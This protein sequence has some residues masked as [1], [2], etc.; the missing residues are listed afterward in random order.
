MRNAPP[1]Y[2]PTSGRP[3]SQLAPDHSLGKARA[4]HG[5]I[6]VAGVTSAFCPPTGMKTNHPFGFAQGRLSTVHTE[7]DFCKTKLCVRRVGACP[8][9]SRRVVNDFRLSRGD[10][11]AHQPPSSTSN[12]FAMRILPVS[13]ME[14]R[15]CRPSRKPLKTGGLRMQLSP[16]I[17]RSY[18]QVRQ[19]K[20]LTIFNF[21]RF[22]SCHIHFAST[23]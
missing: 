1:P 9:R 20:D 8:E 4:H 12:S 21:S 3:L 5:T 6:L 16:M 2:Q 10:V 23:S 14:S 19:N 17:G 7:K 22:F 18:G 13:S 15:S 11:R